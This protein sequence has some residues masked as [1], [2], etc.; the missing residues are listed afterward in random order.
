M[1]RITK[2]LFALMFAALIAM[3][4]TVFA[5]E[6]FKIPNHVLQISKEN[7]FP[8]PAA[9]QEIV[10]PSK[11]TKELLDSSNEKLDNPD[12]IR[13]LNETAIKPSPVAIGYRATIYL[14]HWALNYKSTDTSVNWQYKL[15]N[16]NE[17]GNFE[18]NETRKMHYAQKQEATVKG[19]LTNRIRH[20]DDVKKMMLLQAKDKTKLPL[21]E[22]AVYG[23][24]TKTD[25]A[26]AIPAEK[27][28]ELSAFSAAVNERGEAS[29]GE[30]Y[31]VLK[32]SKK[33]LMVKNVTK[34][35]IGGWI[36]IQD[37]VSFSMQIK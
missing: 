23:K 33:Q 18:G 12:L 25:N 28:G 37:H 5:K 20:S 19:A 4:Y 31:L 24:G 32:G 2:P 3:P 8:N 34:Q 10:K 13:M 35:G 22:Q 7:T 17:Q 26:Y 1:R 36:P 11:E 30:V 14:G 9:D 29:F 16:K 6:N 27:T 15:I 21:A